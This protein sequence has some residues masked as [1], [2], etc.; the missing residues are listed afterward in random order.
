M[1]PL[2]LIAMSLPSTA[3]AA[4]PS[5][6]QKLVSEGPKP[7]MVLRCG[8][9]GIISAGA[10]ALA[11]LPLPTGEV[12]KALDPAG[13]AAM[14]AAGFDLDAPF[15]VVAWK[16]DGEEVL[17]GTF[18]FRGGA[19]SAE[20]WLSDLGTP[21]EPRGP[22]VWG[23]GKKDAQLRL[24][25]GALRLERG[26]PPKGTWTPPTGLLEGIPDDGCAALLFNPGD[27]E[28]KGLVAAAL[29]GVPATYQ[30][31]SE[32]LS[33][34]RGRV[35][36]AQD[37]PAM[38][39]A[40]TS[41]RPELGRSRAE[42]L[43]VIS[44]S[45]PL[46]A[47]IEGVAATEKLPGKLADLRAP[48]GAVGD[49]LEQAGVQI[50]GGTSVAVWRRAGLLRQG[51]RVSFAAVIPVRTAGGGHIPARRLE[52][53]VESALAGRG[54]TVGHQDGVL[55]VHV[56]GKT[57]AVSARRDRLYVASDPELLAESTARLRGHPW[58]DRAFQ[59]FAADWGLAVVKGSGEGANST[60]GARARGPMIELSVE[61]DG[62]ELGG[63]A[64]MLTTMALSRLGR[65]L[66]DLFKY[67]GDEVT[68]EPAPM[69]ETPP[70]QE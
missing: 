15:S 22:G 30:G 3:L 60:L 34:L 37:A 68:S 59:R 69:E 43:A 14:A 26:V 48:L 28:L 47:L 5:A 12:G 49:A 54:V 10:D 32:G 31:S 66:E 1:S 40:T 18:P 19:A 63:S 46:S 9:L 11:S 44:L 6:L 56:G 50:P 53:G 55:M 27:K 4:E 2:R 36:L 52:Q 17:S 7:E 13:T 24:S 42:P 64:A 16:V 38:V 20:A 35:L 67:V 65:E 25:E 45:L 70:V 41:S 29:Y 21:L 23:V 33:T 62:S 58:A 61:S 39:Q 57:F 8:S 51:P